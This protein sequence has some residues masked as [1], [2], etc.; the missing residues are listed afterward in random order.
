MTEFEI[1][2]DNKE[3]LQGFVEEG[4][5]MLEEVEPQ[6]M[7]LEQIAEKYGE[8]DKETINAIFRLFHSLK[9]GAGFLDLG[10]VQMVTH[11]A[12]T[13]LDLFRKGKANIE[14][15]HIDLMIKTCDF[16]RHLLQSVDA[17]GTDKG[18]EDEAG[19]IC[20]DI[21]EAIK[22]IP[23]DSERSKQTVRKLEKKTTKVGPEPIVESREEEED[24]FQLEITD[25]MK[26]QFVA[27][28]QELMETTESALLKLENTVDD[29][30]LLNQAFRAIHSFKGNAGFLG[31]ADLQGISHKCETVLDKMRSNEILPSADIFTLLLEIIDFIRTGINQIAEG[32]EPKIGGFQ[33]IVYL[34]DDMIAKFSIV[35]GGIEVDSEREVVTEEDH[36]QGEEQDSTVKSGDDIEEEQPDEQEIKVKKK[37]LPPRGKSTEEKKSLSA[38]SN[39]RQSIRVEISKLDQLL[40]LVGELVIV[41]AMVAQ[42]P[43]L[44]MAAEHMNRLE[45]SLTQLDKITRDLQDIST[46]IRMVPLAATFK[47]MIRLVRDL[48]QKAGK[49]V[50]LEIIGE[51]TEVDKTVIEQIT[52]PLIH[53]I[54]NSIDHGIEPMIVRKESGK[55][56]SGKLILEAKHIGGEVWIMVKDDGKGLDRD[57]ILK[58]AWDKGLIE[59]DGSEMTDDEVWQLV[60]APGF[61]TADKVTDVS[62]RGVGMDV[63]RRNIEN[64]RGKVEV[65]SARGKGSSVVLRIPL[66]LAIIDGMIVRLG[67][68]YYIIPI[69]D[70][71]ESIRPKESQVTHMA[72]GGEIVNIRGKL[73]PVVRLN[74]LFKIEMDAVNLEEGLIIVVENQ[75]RT[76]CIFVDELVGQQQVVIKGLSSYVGNIGYVSGCTILGDGTVSLIVDMTGI[77]GI[78]E[79]KIAQMNQGV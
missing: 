60:F 43:D 71:K 72:D 4:F 20:D 47:R 18:S 16:I 61:S 41:E 44:K 65:K 58:K 1:F 76:F 26:Q 52:D 19:V 75:D 14:S 15:E 30:E 57:K 36:P 32:K 34:L 64:I 39:G 73:L 66:T 23:D 63:V 12:E 5:E 13:L 51:E 68:H 74:E 8:I 50:E 9:G 67:K 22:K 49:K 55:N 25:E 54:R 70:I 77:I 7:E 21:Q 40:D 3:L 56:D 17:S 6:I 48:S 11:D 69:I 35:P 10:T 33:G 79:N 29:K 53:I 37:V 45:R 62:G 28:G 38:I 24:D 31:Y 2:D 27:E 42:N 78:I 59:N 46:S